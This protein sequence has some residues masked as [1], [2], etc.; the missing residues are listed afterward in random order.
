MKRFHAKRLMRLAKFLPTINPSQ[1]N[2]YAWHE[3]S[4]D[5]GTVACAGG[6]ACTI[7]AFKKAGL[8]LIGSVPRCLDKDRFPV[9]GFGAMRVFFGVDSSQS[10]KVF[11]A[12]GYRDENE[13]V[14]VIVTPQMVATRI[15]DLVRDIYPDI[16]A[17]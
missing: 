4:S 11:T 7:P 6:W 8:H 9:S 16:A 2:I 3:K 10:V 14:G 12:D 13:E 1:F 17:A 5:C 15:T